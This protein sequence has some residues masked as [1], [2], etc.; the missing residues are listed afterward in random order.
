GVLK[1]VVMRLGVSFE[2]L[3]ETRQIEREQ[4][5]AVAQLR[6][7][8]EVNA[9]LLADG[10]VAIL[11]LYGFHGKPLLKLDSV[12][13]F[14]EYKATLHAAGCKAYVVNLQASASKISETCRGS[15]RCAHHSSATSRSP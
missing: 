12:Y 9:Q 8:L 1:I 10:C 15:G 4:R 7:V 13:N 3:L 14:F 2:T 6:T 11:V 5:N